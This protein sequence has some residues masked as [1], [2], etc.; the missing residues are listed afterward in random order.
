MNIATMQSNTR[1]GT[2]T[3]SKARMEDVPVFVVYP[4]PMWGWAVACRGGTQSH[5]FTDK[6]LAINYAK[7]WAEA[8]RPSVVR[9]ETPEGRIEAQWEYAPFSGSRVVG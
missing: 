9:V 8:N 5:T 7:S 1:S 3:R 6:N 4:G 2:G